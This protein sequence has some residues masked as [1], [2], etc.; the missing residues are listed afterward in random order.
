MK[1]IA[2]IY[3]SPYGH[4]AKLAHAVK[5]GA[6][7][8]PGVAATLHPVTTLDDTARCGGA[9]SRADPD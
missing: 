6:D 8:V 7:S 5:E 4:T 2:V 1:R 3:D 9:G